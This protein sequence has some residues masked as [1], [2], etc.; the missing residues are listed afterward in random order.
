M[1]TRNIFDAIKYPYKLPSYSL[2]RQELNIYKKM[3]NPVKKSVHFEIDDYSSDNSDNID[4][5]DN[6]ENNKLKNERKT[7][8]ERNW[9]VNIFYSFYYLFK[10]S[11]KYSY[12]FL[13][14]IVI[15]CKQYKRYTIFGSGVGIGCSIYYFLKNK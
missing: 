6:N 13:K 3:L 14:N 15:Y 11:V 9:F 7:G 4:D 10:Y 8:K 12:N 1:Y 2:Y 5:N